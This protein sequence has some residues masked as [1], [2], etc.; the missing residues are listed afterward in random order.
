MAF[1]PS[2]SGQPVTVYDEGIT[3]TSAVTSLNF[4]GAGVTATAIGN[5]VT[6]TIPSGGGSG[7]V[8]S[9]AMNV[10][11]GL[12]VTGSPVTTSGTLAVTLTSGYVIPT[13]A[14]L[15]A[16]LENITG[17]VTQG[18]GITITG[19]G[20]SG[21]PYVINAT[22]GGTGTV[23]SVS[24]VTAN[25]VSGSVATA[26][27]T[28]A[29][30]L[31]LG[32]ITP[33]SVNG[34]TISTTT[35][36]LTVTNGKTLAVTNSLTLSGTD[37]TVMT[38]P[39]TSQTVAGLTATQTL[40]NKRVTPRVT[41]ITSSATPTPNADTDDQYNVNALAENATFGAP[42][43]T[44]TDG[45]VLV[46]RITTASYYTMTWDAAYRSTTNNVYPTDSGEAGFFDLTTRWNASASK[47]DLV[48]I[49]YIAS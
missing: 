29:I 5:D 1:N 4:T 47:W 23:T 37:S 48:N 42:T 26:T 22:G 7:T 2:A 13:V 30:T 6:V 33:T 9:V 49:A 39:S 12:T 19:S 36:T 45:Q 8:T 41:S 11:T 34:L 25:G 3:L 35:G 20:T 27:T 28:P 44:P 24:V 38:F 18:S 32:A 21:D 14:A 43:G 15:A 16:K 46:I 40:T 10:P 17:L 31:T